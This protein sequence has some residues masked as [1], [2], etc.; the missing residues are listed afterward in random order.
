VSEVTA[1]EGPSLPR[2]RTW[3]SA[4][5]IDLAL[6]VLVVAAGVGMRR[7]I[8]RGSLGQP[9]L[10]EATV[11]VQALRFGRGQL[12]TFFPNQAYGGTVEP[13]LVAMVF[14]FFGSSV[15]TLKVV[16]MACA[17]L[18]AYLTHRSAARLG[19]GMTGRWTAAILVW[20]GP[21]F[22]VA[23]STKER[24]FYGVALA[25]AAAQ[26]L[27]VL[28]LDEQPKQGD[29]I[30]LGAL[31]GLGW[32]Q[33][34]LT[35]L[36]AVP[37]LGWLAVRRSHLLTSDYAAYG[38]LLLGALPWFVWNARNHWLS[39]NGG[40]A[41][42]T[43]WWQRVETW[44]VK[45]RV[46]IG[47]ETPFDASRHLVGGRWTGAL[48]VL[49]VL[50]VATWRT[51][52]DAPALLA[53]LTVGYG[54]LY[55]L[56]GLAAGVGSDPRYTYLLVPVLAL[57]V[58]SLLPD[59]LSDLWSAAVVLVVGMLVTSMSAWGLAGM[60]R[61]AEQPQADKFLS[62][63]GIEDVV[64]FLDRQRRG[65]VLTDIA[66]SQITYLSHERI[67]AA[68][69]S[70]PRF[71]D[72]ELAA[73]AAKRS[74]YVLDDHALGNAGRLRL[75]LEFHRIPY[76]A[77]HIGKWWVYLLDRRV[78]PEQARLLYFEIDVVRR[79]TPKAKPRSGKAKP[80]PPKLEPLHP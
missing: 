5:G 49:V 7:W 41:F 50:A 19:M 40:Y 10:D 61:A 42:G 25:L 37:A 57:A 15:L 35:M 24:G 27:L 6:G 2:V 77:R 52:D 45:L 60:E 33:T 55:G 46:D 11:G 73:R 63:P 47:I 38:A 79:E 56:N 20:V 14:R 51:W 32:W 78:L 64:T 44:L 16:P 62:S 12:A 29:L 18:A 65:P 72:L 9:D 75:Y 36:V 34:P 69:F 70:V 30:L 28:R 13:F 23:F 31:V 39:M 48:I 68:S 3:V 8:L 1:A 22:A 74:T 59:L 67:Q 21:A 53:V 66:G 17:G 76:R 80:H 58:A 43:S 54:A 4:H 26:V 71:H